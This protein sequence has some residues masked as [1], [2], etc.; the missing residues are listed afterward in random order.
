MDFGDAQLRKLMEA[1]HQEVALRELNAPLRDP[2]S[3]CWGTPAG[4][5]EDPSLDDQEVTFPRE[6]G[7]KPRGHQP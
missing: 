4:H 7:W 2:T 6:R 3:G 5:R 1:L